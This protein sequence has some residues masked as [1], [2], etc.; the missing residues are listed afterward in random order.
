MSNKKPDFSTV[1]V[2][3]V[4]QLSYPHV[5]EPKFNPLAK[6][7]QYSIQMLFAKTEKAQL[8]PMNELVTKLIAWKWGSNVTG[9]KRPFQDGDTI[10]DQAGTLKC[11]KNPSYNGMILL[12][13][14]S[15]QQPGIVDG[16][17]KH[18]ITQED[19]IYGGCYCCAQLNAYCYEQGGNRGVSFGL[20]HIQK[21]KDGK[22]FGNRTRAEDAFAPVENAG[23]EVAEDEFFK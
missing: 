6:R 15:R 23:A 10:K 22:P 20:M 3:P 2:T 8:L 5:W 21:R 7:E 9:I 11:E 18:P 1:I 12:S 16:T 19:E 14:W 13:S 17:G 4:F